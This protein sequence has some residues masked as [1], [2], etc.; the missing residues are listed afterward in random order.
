MQKVEVADTHPL[1]QCQIRWSFAHAESCNSL[2]WGGPHFKKNINLLGW[3]Q[4]G[5]S[6]VG[7]NN[8]KRVNRTGIIFNWHFGILGEIG[9][10]ATLWIQVPPEK[11]L[12]PPNCTLSAFIAATW[13]HRANVAKGN[14]DG[15]IVPLFFDR[16]W[17]LSW[18][19]LMTPD[20]KRTHTQFCKLSFFL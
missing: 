1:N 13:I 8:K 11:I 2:F 7:F 20:T 18:S 6:N 17:S 3:P 4:P 9:S 15:F 12:Y 14:F 5:T 10:D 16:A 19:W